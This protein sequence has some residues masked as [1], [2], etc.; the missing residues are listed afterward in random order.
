MDTLFFI[1][2]FMIVLAVIGALAAMLGV[3]SRECIEDT[4]QAHTAGGRL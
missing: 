2:A 1:S 4:H 3:D